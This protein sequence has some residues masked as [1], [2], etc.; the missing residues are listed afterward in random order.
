MIPNPNNFYIKVTRIY[1]IV[2]YTKTNSRKL[3]KKITSKQP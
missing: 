2:Y 3:K 1:Y